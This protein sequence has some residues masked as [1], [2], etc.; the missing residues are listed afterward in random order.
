MATVMQSFLSL[1][2]IVIL[3][4]IIYIIF[5]KPI[6]D[7]WGATKEE[8]NMT[9]IG[10]ELAPTIISTRAISI[11][12]PM[13]EVWQWLIQLGADRGGFFSYT[14]IEKALGYEARSAEPIPE[15]QDIEVGRIIPASIDESKS[16]IKYNFRV[17]AVE[18]GESIVIEN[19]GALVLQKMD[20]QRT[21]FIVR[22]HGQALPT[23]KSKI[24]DF[25]GMAAHYIM[26]RRMMLGFKAQA[27][28]GAGVHLSALPDNLWLLGIFL[29]GL[30]ILVILFLNARIT[31]FLFAAVYSTLWLLTLMVLDPKPIFSLMLLLVI[32]FTIFL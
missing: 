7:T 27:E 18:P 14:F 17:T 31:S 32:A 2:L 21:R 30:G 8:A 5:L 24:G 10:D 23:L 20:A 19:W 15:F 29:S 16:L 3:E 12:A 9:L 6:V 28:A 1:G 26:E 11:N 13:S 4:I 22:T 25:L